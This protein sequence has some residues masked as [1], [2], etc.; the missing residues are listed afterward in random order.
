MHI[1][2]HH[3]LYTTLS[4]A[5]CSMTEHRVRKHTDEDSSNTGLIKD[6]T[7]KFSICPDNKHSFTRPSQ[8]NFNQ[9]IAHSHFGINV[10]TSGWLIN[11]TQTQMSSNC[12]TCQHMNNTLLIITVKSLLYFQHWHS[13]SKYVYFALLHSFTRPHSV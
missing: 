4:L 11:T 10:V 13:F 6:R 5:C 1:T 12:R 7:Q 2:S 3:I 8:S 9:Q